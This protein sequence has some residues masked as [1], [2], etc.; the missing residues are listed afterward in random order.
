M[1]F[2]DKLK[3]LRFQKEWSQEEMADFLETS[4]QVISRY[5]NSQTTPKIDV[6]IKYANKLNV[7]VDAL[8][9]NTKSELDLFIKKKPPI[10]C[11]VPVLGKVTAGI[12][13]DAVE[14]IVDYEEISEE[15]ASKGDYFGLQIKGDSMEPKFSEG[16]V[17]IVRKQS[18][19]Q[20][21]EIAIVL[22]NGDEAT[23]KKVMLFEGGINLVPSNQAYQ[24]ITFTNDQIEKLPV[25]ILGKVVEL[26]AKF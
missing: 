7:S 22:I 17:V 2:G 14:Y 5:E 26:R 12:P 3:Y 24:V 21:G 1:N 13:I 4:K 19:I 25:Q 18:T 11:L 15:M 6:A 10:R 9:D 23:I 20:S 16:D 8:I